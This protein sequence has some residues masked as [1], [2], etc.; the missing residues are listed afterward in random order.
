MTFTSTSNILEVD[1]LSISYKKADHGLNS[2]R[3]F[4]VRFINS[5][6]SILFSKKDRFEVLNNITFNIKKGERVALLGVNGAGKT[7]LCRTISGMHGNKPNIK[8][9]GQ[10][11][12]IFDTS[13]VVQPDLSGKENAWILTNLLFSNY[14]KAER[15]EIIKDSLEFSELGHFVHAP[16]KQYSKGMKTRLFLSVVSARPSDLLILDEVFSGADTFFNEKITAR[17]EKMIA[18]SGAVIFI[19][20]IEDIVNRVCNRGIVLHNKQIA[21]DGDI[22]K[23]TEFYNNI[24]QSGLHT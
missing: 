19:S 16:F 21:F 7:S 15:E 1:S 9:N 3:D 11:R 8:L 6:A 14:S 5:P 20:H 17:V 23:A 2:L 10:A 12:A 4:F 22:K 13:V 18:Q 24:H